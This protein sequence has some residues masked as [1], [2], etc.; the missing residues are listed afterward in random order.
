MNSRFK[1][2]KIE[3][4]PLLYKMVFAF[5]LIV[6]IGVAI[7][8]IAEPAYG[9]KSESID[10]RVISKLQ[11]LENDLKAQ[12]ERITQEKERQVAFMDKELDY[13]HQMAETTRSI[14]CAEGATLYCP[15]IEEIVIE[16]EPLG[17]EKLGS[18]LVVGRTYTVTVTNYNPVPG[19]T[20]GSPCIGASGQDL[21]ELA[22]D[23]VKIIA[24]SQELVGR[25]KYKPFK[26]GDYVQVNH[27]NIWCKGVYKVMDTMN[28]RH[29][30]HADIFKLDPNDNFGRCDGAEIVKVYM[31]VSP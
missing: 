6:L 16:A 19:Q 31:G 5:S 27:D 24:L 23:G 29:Y 7:I 9:A 4:I 10:R 21:C 26:Y 1:F 25:A 18:P 3:K 2:H 11:N 8:C 30:L 28:A 22:R 15:E 13:T 12:F 17:F 14:L 20:D